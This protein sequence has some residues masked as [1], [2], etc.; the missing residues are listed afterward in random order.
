[1]SK[2][3][4]SFSNCL[5]LIKNQRLKLPVEHKCCHFKSAWVLNKNHTITENIAS[6]KVIVL[7]N[8]KQPVVFYHKF[9]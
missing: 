7:T 3:I 9:P 1:M 5:F 6:L 8:E 4:K 2:S